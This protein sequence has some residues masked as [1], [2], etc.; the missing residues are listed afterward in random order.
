MDCIPPGSSVHGIFQA[1]L[2]EWVVT[3]S[4]RRSSQS[5]DQTQ[6]SLILYHLSHQQIL[7]G[8]WSS[9]SNFSEWCLLYFLSQLSLLNWN[10]HPFLPWFVKFSTSACPLPPK[11]LSALLLIYPSYNR[12]CYL[13]KKKAEE[14]EEERKE[15]TKSSL[16]IS[17]VSHYHQVQYSRTFHEGRLCSPHSNLPGILDI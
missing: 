15:N 1:R 6:I 4:S 2:L 8:E 3:S 14:E 16:K 13:L 9:W 5:R 11:G 7:S 12:K 10:S 17:I